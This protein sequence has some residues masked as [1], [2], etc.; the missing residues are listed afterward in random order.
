MALTLGITW[1]IARGSDDGAFSVSTGDCVKQES[2]KAVT[3][4]CG[5]AGA[6]VVTSIVNNKDQCPDRN[7]PYVVNTTSDNKSQILCLKPG[8]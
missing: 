6:F 1:L 8:T 4:K 3:A 2:G 7:Q 5:D